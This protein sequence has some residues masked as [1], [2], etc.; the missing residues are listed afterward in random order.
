[1]RYPNKFCYTQ[2]PTHQNYLL[3]SVTGKRIPETIFQV[4]NISVLSVSRLILRSH[5]QAA[6][7]RVSLRHDR[8]VF[9]SDHDYCASRTTCQYDV[10]N[11]L[12]LRKAEKTGTLT[13]DFMDF[14]GLVP[15]SKR[16]FYPLIESLQES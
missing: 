14:Y 2:R 4:F 6:F 13:E 7:H 5:N 9:G 10:R 3:P 15:C 16:K 12:R 1:V 11:Y 8:Q